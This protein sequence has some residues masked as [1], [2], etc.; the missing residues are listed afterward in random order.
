M[1]VEGDGVSLTYTGRGSP[2]MLIGDKRRDSLSK[3]SRIGYITV[4]SWSDIG[5]DGTKQIA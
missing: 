4:K 3:K 2:P 1:E 5:N